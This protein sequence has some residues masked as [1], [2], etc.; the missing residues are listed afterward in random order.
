MSDHDIA[1]A[2]IT[3]SAALLELPIDTAWLPTIRA[4]VEVTLRLAKLVD[5]FP[6]PDEAEPAPVFGA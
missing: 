1:D 5:D 4:N 3:S 2:W 6:L